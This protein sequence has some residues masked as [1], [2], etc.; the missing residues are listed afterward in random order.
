MEAPEVDLQGCKPFA[1]GGCRLIYPDPRN[2]RHCLKITVPG[3]GEGGARRAEVGLLRWVHR[4]DYY[5]E[6]S[7]QW[8]EHRKYAR[9]FRRVWPPHLAACH[10]FVRTPV[11]RGL[12]VDRVTN[13]DGSAALNAREYLLE[14][15]YDEALRTALK[16]LR[17][18]LRRHRVLMRDAMADNIV[19]RREADGRLTAVIIDGLGNSEF[20]PLSDWFP[21]SGRR[22]VRLRWRA[23]LK[24][25]RLIRR[26]ARRGDV[27]GLARSHGAAKGLLAPEGS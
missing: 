24:N 3:G 22:K 10:G 25:V 9:R 2:P 21:P 7:R 12:V 15:G 19:L 16:E 11:G 8:R 13:A 1:R 26:R 17:H 20:I 5:D 6:N 14:H 23:L 4:P 27:V 18:F